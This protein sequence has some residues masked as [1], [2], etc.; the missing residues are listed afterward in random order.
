MS[1]SILWVA[2]L[3]ALVLGAC[4]PGAQG[5][6]MEGGRPVETGNGRYMDV[7]VP[8]MQAMMESE[9]VLL[10]NVHVP[11]A[12]NIP[13][14]D[15]SIPYNQIAQNAD[16]LPA[17]KDARILVYCR[18]GAMSAEAARALVNMGYAN[19]W[20]LSGGMNA[21]QGAGMPLEMQP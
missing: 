12:G 9:D 2:L 8:E 10:V 18:S 20:N 6:V 7:T 4:S 19:V 3:A 14:T 5:A 15:L 13:G 1:R 17:D 21:W 16:L 11:F